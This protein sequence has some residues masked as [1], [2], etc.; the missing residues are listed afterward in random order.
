[1]PITRLPS[2]RQVSTAAALFLSLAFLARL[3][4]GAQPAVNV[5]LTDAAGKTHSLVDFKGK[6]AVV[7][8]FLSFDCPVSNSY[9]PL[10]A[11]LHS[12]YE[13]RGVAFLGIDSSDDL[14]AKQV[15]T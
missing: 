13:S 5:A 15:A 14:D 8:V 4:E 10:L 11:Q 9:A 6:K 2:D 7:A 12:K 1:M 3:A